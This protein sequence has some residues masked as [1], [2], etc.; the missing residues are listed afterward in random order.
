MR[1]HINA[2]IRIL[3]LVII[4]A[5]SAYSI[6]VFKADIELKEL[7]NIEKDSTLYISAADLNQIL[8][9]KTVWVSER[10][11]LIFQ[12]KKHSITVTPENPYIVFEE[13]TYVC[14]PI[15]E[16]IGGDLYIPVERWISI[17][18]EA[19]PGLVEWDNA[20]KRIHVTSGESFIRKVS[21]SD[22]G[23]ETVISV[24]T[25]QPV[26]YKTSLKRSSLLLN[27]P[28]TRLPVSEISSKE[29]TGLVESVEAFQL[30]NLSQISFLLKEGTSIKQSMFL[31]DPYRIQIVLHKGKPEQE[32]DH[33]KPITSSNRL[34]EIRTVVIDAGHGGKDPGAIGYNG[35]RE[36][37]MTL[38]IALEI[39]KELK[40]KTDL[41]V[42][43]TRE[44]DVFLKLGTRTK[45]AN[46]KGADLFISV[47]CNSIA[48]SKRRKRNVYGYKAYILSPA[49]NTEDKMVAMKENSVI[50]FEMEDEEKKNL[51]T[52]EDIL[53]NMLS[54]E[55]L[56]ESVDWASMIVSEMD[57]KIKNS[58]RLHTGLG[59]AG[60]YVLNG[61]YMPAVL[62][63]VGFISNPNESQIIKTKKFQTNVAES[64]VN[65]ILSFKKKYEEKG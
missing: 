45:I 50:S 25:N 38:K 16:M 55:F 64:V 4:A 54:N 51:S 52:T 9:G 17:I 19:V 57:K 46:K 26:A 33:D 36:K 30:K 34:K 10:G 48:G 35:L 2:I 21:C 14:N 5:Q 23:E 53:W 42:V 49:K 62:L 15:P 29:K 59:Q 27:L 47:H 20:K 12:F 41:N 24:H 13:K 18:N 56:K 37:D 65:S 39:K 8:N 1:R 63:E 31:K 32:Q 6:P 22:K 40:K 61:T 3:G 44:E 28:E 11:K 7:R 43:L 60:F 58:R